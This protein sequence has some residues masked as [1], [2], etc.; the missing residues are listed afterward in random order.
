MS[1]AYTAAE[2]E[3]KHLSKV[4][5][6]GNFSKKKHVHAVSDVDFKIP[7]GQT[8]GLVG[9]SGCGKSTLGRMLLRLIPATGGEVYL[10]GENVLNSDKKRIWELRR[11]MQIIFQ[12]QYSS[13]NPKM[14]ILDSVKAPLDAYK[15]GSKQERV[16]RVREIFRLVGLSEKHF[17]R[18]P[19]EF[20]GGQRQR[21]VIARALVS[22]PSFI[23]A[24]EPVSSL[25]VSVRAQILNLMKDIQTGFGI[26][27]LFISHD[28]SV[29]YHISDSVAVMYLGRIVELAPK[30]H[31]FENPLH[32]YTKAL[33]S[34]LLVPGEDSKQRIILHG[35]VPS[36]FDIPS[37]CSFRKRCPH[38]TE[39]CRSERPALRELSNGHSVA[40]HHTKQEDAAFKPLDLD[41]N[42]II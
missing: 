41:E 4:Y 15:I 37:G 39:G 1:K 12:N 23:V 31:L 27:Y 6:Q 24:D 7:S 5:S 19:H 18:Y 9:E 2:I 26:T 11:K 33:L 42:F 22:D 17:D 34:S 8:L 16:D 29:V 3:V 21:I 36:P 10:N 28:L 25:D 20:S 32:P 14:R 13:L 35:E 40:C 38:A 30:K